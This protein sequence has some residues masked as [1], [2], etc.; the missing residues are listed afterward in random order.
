MRIGVPGFEAPDLNTIKVREELM[1]R[2]KIYS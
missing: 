1:M 2:T